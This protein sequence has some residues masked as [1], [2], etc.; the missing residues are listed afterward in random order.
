[1]EVE[2]LGGCWSATVWDG[3]V[4]RDLCPESGGRGNT[5]VGGS[6]THMCLVMGW[7]PWAL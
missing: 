2:S 1:M 6:H 7:G 5:V 4:Q 3:P